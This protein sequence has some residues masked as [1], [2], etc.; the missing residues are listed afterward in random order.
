[1][2]SHTFHKIDETNIEVTRFGAGPPLLLLEGEEQRE[3]RLPFVAELAKRFEVIIPSPPGFGKSNRP[4]CV[5]SMDDIAYIYN[6]LL[7]GLDLSGVVALGFSMGGWIA[8]EMASKSDHRLAKL[9]LVSPFGVKHGGPTDRDIADIWILHPQDRKS[10]RLN[11][12]HIPLSRM[13]SSA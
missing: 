4:D 9:I 2:E 13:P 11:S 10:T 12:S 8:A 6:S 7:Q 3:R 5:T 1:M